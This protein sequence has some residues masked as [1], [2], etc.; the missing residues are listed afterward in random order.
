MKDSGPAPGRPSKIFTAMG[1]RLV[2]GLAAE[3]RVHRIG[4]Q[5]ASGADLL[6][7]AQGPDGLTRLLC[8]W[9]LSGETLTP[10]ISPVEIG[11]TFLVSRG[12]IPPWMQE[13]RPSL[14]RPSVEAWP[15]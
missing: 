3:V 14:V 12:R 1:K 4:C 5:V 2:P 11:G 8:P 13:L 6:G 9:L 10:P 7:E 15:G